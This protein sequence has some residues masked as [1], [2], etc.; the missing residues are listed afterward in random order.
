MSFARNA[1]AQISVDHGAGSW[2]ICPDLDPALGLVS[3]RFDAS[4]SP[5]NPTERLHGL[6]TETS[7]I[8]E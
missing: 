5:V 4:F 1:Y 7:M 8:D 2:K 3:C 6:V